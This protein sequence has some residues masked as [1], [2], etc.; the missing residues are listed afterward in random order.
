VTPV[1][2]APDEMTQ[3]DVCD[4]NAR[5]YAGRAHCALEAGDPGA[6]IANALLAIEARLEEQ[7]YYLGDIGAGTANIG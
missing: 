5:H 4:A 1:S 2:A 3:R 6:A 7:T